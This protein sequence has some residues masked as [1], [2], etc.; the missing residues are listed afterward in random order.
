MIWTSVASAVIAVVAVVTSVVIYRKAQ[1]GEA[2]R[3]RR[4]RM[5]V[6]TGTIPDQQIVVTNAGTGP[7]LNVFLVRGDPGDDDRIALTKEQ[8]AATTWF[9]PVHLMPI[10]AGGQ[11]TLPR[12]Y[13]KWTSLDPWAGCAIVYTDAFG[14]GYTTLANGTGSRV[15]E[16][17]P[18]FAWD[19][20]K[21]PYPG[22]LTGER[23]WLPEPAHG[24]ERSQPVEDTI[25]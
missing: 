15:H 17:T 20:A 11:V 3:E 7:A 21:V 18:A 12:V 2:V 23:R 5:P 16:G 9:N 1:A 19:P 22:E 4:R 13:L 10:P 8:P 14:F 24:W 6:L 25:E